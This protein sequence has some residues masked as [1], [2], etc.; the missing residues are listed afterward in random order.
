MVNKRI[1]DFCKNYLADKDKITLEKL[2]NNF[3][4]CM[5]YLETLEL[6]DD[7]KVLVVDITTNLYQAMVILH[8]VINWVYL[9]NNED[10]EL[11][12]AYEDKFSECINNTYRTAELV[13]NK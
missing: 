12:Q 2:N 10:T 5:N 8:S 13:V 6:T 9:P 4:T 11:K 3:E 1:K 7:D